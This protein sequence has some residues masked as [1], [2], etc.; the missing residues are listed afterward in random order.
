MTP[1]NLCRC[2][3]PAWTVHPDYQVLH[4]TIRT[5]STEQANALAGCSMDSAFLHEEALSNIQA[6]KA[7]IWTL[8]A[9]ALLFSAEGRQP[10]PLVGLLSF[11][12]LELR[13]SISTRQPKFAARRGLSWPSRPKSGLCGLT[14]GSLPTSQYSRCGVLSLSVMLSGRRCARSA[15]CSTTLDA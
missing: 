1:A 5:R 14:A 15:A 13:R 12:Q 8:A 11:V 6:N 4:I 2:G 10:C 3:S 9:V 7:Q